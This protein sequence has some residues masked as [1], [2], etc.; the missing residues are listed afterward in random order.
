MAAMKVST[1]N[2]A[3]H[4]TVLLSAVQDLKD[5]SCIIAI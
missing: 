1:K 4:E 3:D 2:K 5:N